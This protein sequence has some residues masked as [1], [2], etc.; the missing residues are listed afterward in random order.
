[1]DRS[2]YNS[3][4]QCGSAA[5]RAY[6]KT[7]GP[8]GQCDEY[9]FGVALEGGAINYAAGKV[10]LKLIDGTDN[11]VGGGTFSTFLEFCGVE[12]FARFKVVIVSG[13]TGGTDR[14]G[15]KCY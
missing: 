12:G 14:N 4:P 13:A 15:S 6:K 2:W 9:P 11:Q 7:I 1:V 5:R 3:T 8:G 10:S